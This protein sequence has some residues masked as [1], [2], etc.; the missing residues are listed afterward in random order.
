MSL[1]AI[2]LIVWAWRTDRAW[3]E[4][5]V[6]WRYCAAEPKELTRAAIQR[7][8]AVVIA[9]VL[10]AFA[11]PRWG[12]WAA[13]RSTP[14][15]GSLAPIAIACLLA[16]VACDLLLRLPMFRAKPLRPLPFIVSEPRSLWHNAVSS[17]SVETYEGRQVAYAIDAAGNRVRSPQDQADPARPT[18]VFAGESVGFGFGVDYDDTYPVRVGAALGVQEVNI[19]VSAYGNDQVYMRTHAELP[20]FAKPIAVVTL[21]MPAQL[22]RNV[23]RARPHYLPHDDGSIEEIPPFPQ[24]IVDSPLRQLFLE[25]VFPYRSEE[26]FRIARATFAATAREAEARGAYPLFVLSN[27]GSPCMPAE[28]GTTPMD[29]RLF[30]GLN[31]HTI[32]V[33]LD[34]T[35]WD[36]PSDHPDGRAHAV[37]ANAI[38]DAL[39]PHLVAMPSPR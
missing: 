14:T 11:R 35:L 31:L 33:V 39:R 24:L 22:V 9:V 29:Q 10:F 7:G 19:A 37:L 30:G 2:A 23:D 12:R 13:A 27:W 16:L 36:K 8:V 34:T 26:T 32:E 1:V 21:V 17:F 15:L 38:T 28:E 5:H 25:N 18:I 20:R 4:D 6:F 3:F